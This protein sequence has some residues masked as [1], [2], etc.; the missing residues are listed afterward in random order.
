MKF[1]KNLEELK[2]FLQQN[3]KSS[4]TLLLSMIVFLFWVFG[5]S[6][7]EELEKVDKKIIRPEI[8]SI[9]DAVDPRAVWVDN[10]S[11]HIESMSSK[12]EASL[13]EQAELNQESINLL[14][15]D[16][17]DIKTQNL[18]AIKIK[19]ENNSSIEVV[20]ENNEEKK[21]QPNLVHLHLDAQNIAV[22]NTDDYVISGSF[23]R[24][25]LL[26]GIVAETG[27]D[28]ASSPQPVL[29]RLVDVGIFSKGYR[30]EQIKEAILIGSC[31]GNISSERS[32]CRL[33]TLSLMNNENKIIER[34]VEGWII[35]E[36]G[37]PGIRGDVVDKSSNITRLAVLNGILGGMAGFFQ[38]QAQSSIFPVSPI[39]GQTNALNGIDSLKAGTASGVGNALQKLADYAIKRA[40]QMSPVIVIGAGRTVDIV[41]KKGFYLKDE[42]ILTD[43]VNNQVQSISSK[44]N[45]IYKEKEIKN[46]GYSPNTLKSLQI[47]KGEF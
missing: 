29:L 23:A 10:I 7:K 26:T 37:R 43:N 13:K 45:P 22:K 20:E 36:D 44:D 8:R 2:I 1:P 28:S 39:S 14:Q 27:T 47:N 32:I 17:E 4:F 9:Q 34:P 6:F 38:S 25:V 30:T 31:Y 19:E 12:F 16:I 35:G 15:K 46:E 33:E 5:G 3:Q 42:N 24:A 41:F 11:Q 40:E 18:Q 21:L